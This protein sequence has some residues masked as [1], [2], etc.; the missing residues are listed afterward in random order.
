MGIPSPPT[1]LWRGRQLSLAGL[2]NLPWPRD[3]PPDTVAVFRARALHEPFPQHLFDLRGGCIRMPA[4]E[5]LAHHPFTRS[6][7]VEGGSQPC[8]RDLLLGHP[9]KRIT[10][11][12]P[13][14]ARRRSVVR[15]G[16]AILAKE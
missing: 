2:R 14:V 5:V 11:A 4:P 8:G 16:R 12:A 10:R 15:G 9:V 13:R 6:E 3:R 1:S 7:E